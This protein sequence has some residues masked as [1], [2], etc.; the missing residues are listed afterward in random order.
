MSLPVR[1]YLLNFDKNLLLLDAIMVVES[2]NVRTY[3][4]IYMDEKSHVGLLKPLIV[5]TCW[6][7]LNTSSG[8]F[9]MS[10]VPA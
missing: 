3:I 1:K 4:G 10:S 7:L 6:Y 8:R 2:V 5:I 9:D